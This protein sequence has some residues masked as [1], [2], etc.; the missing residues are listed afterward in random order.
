MLQSIR[1][2]VEIAFGA[3]VPRII[4]EANMLPHVTT[5]ASIG[6]TLRRRCIRVR[7][8]VEKVAL[9]RGLYILHWLT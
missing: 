4:F 6:S 8:R 2:E 3:S 5:G 7:R 9:Q 1:N